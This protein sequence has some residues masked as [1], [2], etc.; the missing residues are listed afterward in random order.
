MWDV[1]GYMGVCEDN[2]GSRYRLD[3]VRIRFVCYILEF[4]F[5]G[6]FKIGDYYN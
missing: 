3:F 1:R 4:Y 6:L 2:I 5:S